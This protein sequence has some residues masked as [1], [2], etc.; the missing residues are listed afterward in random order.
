[1]IIVDDTNVSDQRGAAA[2]A[3]RSEHPI[4]I[5]NHFNGGNVGNDLSRR[6]MA[7]QFRNAVR[8]AMLER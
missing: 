8:Q 3:A 5:V 7:D 1:V 4:Q 6:A 2:S